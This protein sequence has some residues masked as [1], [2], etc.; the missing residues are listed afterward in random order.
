MKYPNGKLEQ[1]FPS[2][3]CYYLDTEDVVRAYIS[4]K[5]L[6]DLNLWAVPY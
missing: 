1:S 3:S 5:K 6:R 4:G 2:I